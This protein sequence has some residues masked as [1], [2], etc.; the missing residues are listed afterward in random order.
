MGTKA[1]PE[2][3]DW[4]D[5]K[6]MV[7]VARHVWKYVL[8][9]LPHFQSFD[10]SVISE[11]TMDLKGTFITFG[12][13]WGTLRNNGKHIVIGYL[14]GSLYVFGDIVACETTGIVNESSLLLW[15]EKRWHVSEVRLLK[16]PQTKEARGLPAI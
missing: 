6:S 1:K 14:F 2:V 10:Y 3:F 5:I 8:P 4:G 11:N 7:A 16:M 12:N 15:H 9:F 13:D